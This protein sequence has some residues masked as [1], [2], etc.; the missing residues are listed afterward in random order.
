LPF[1]H[2]GDKNFWLDIIH[3]LQRLGHDLDVVSVMVEDVPSEGLPLHR[4]PPIPMY[5]RPDRRFNPSHWHIAGTNNY[6]SKT[7]SLPRIVREVRRRRKEFQPDLIHFIDNY[8][9]GM[10]GLRAAFGNLPLTVSA[11]TYQPNRPMYDVFLR[12]SFASF[13]VIVPFSDAYRKR[14]LELRFPA[15]RVRRIRWGIDVDRFTPP[16]DAQREAVRKELG[17]RRDQLVILWT[18]FI[19]QTGEPDLRLALR[20]AELAIEDDPTK[21]AFLFCFKP[22]HF[23]ESYRS[24]ER[25]GLR[26]FGSAD[27]FHAAR[28]AADIL[29]CP[30]IDVRSTAA[31][32]L[33]WLECLAMGIPILTTEI[34]GVEE[35]VADGKSGFAVPSPE[36]ASDRL[37]ALLADDGLRQRLREG[38]RQIAM[39][40]YS[41]D[42]ALQEYVDLWSTV[43]D[44]SDPRR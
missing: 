24:F 43:A 37:R 34:P 20:T 29:L 9:P 28:T 17:L 44:G 38:A 23:K 2:S 35:A 22:E 32:P 30:F 36:A 31:P 13:D 19:Q 42:R 1:R 6:V 8:G 12:A 33:A 14:L 25:T 41:V 3:G 11:P 5:L 39:E 21:Y 27:A 7:I 16:T 40:R 4:V 15:E 18:G 26:V 10:A